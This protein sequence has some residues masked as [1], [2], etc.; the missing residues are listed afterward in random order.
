MSPPL[1]V[2]AA[3]FV[4]L[5]I[6]AHIGGKIHA[7]YVYRIAGKQIKEAIRKEASEKANLK[8]HSSHGGTA[9]D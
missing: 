4:S 7:R 6:G 2:V 5:I 9:N 8:L 3:F 1:F